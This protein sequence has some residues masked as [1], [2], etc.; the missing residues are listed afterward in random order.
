ILSMQ[1]S[2][3][4]K[5]S[6]Q[7]PNLSDTPTDKSSIDVLD[8]NENLVSVN[9]ER[10][11]GEKSPSSFSSS[12]PSIDS[13]EVDELCQVTGR[14]TLAGNQNIDRAENQSW[15]SLPWPA[16]RRAC[17]YLLIKKDCSNMANLSQVSTHFYTG[18]HQFMKIAENRPALS[19]AHLWRRK[20][21]LAVRVFLYPSNLP[22]Y[23]LASL[24]ARRFSR[25]RNHHGPHVEVDLKGPNDRII[26]QVVNLLSAP[27]G[28]V[29]IQGHVHGF[30]AEDL[31]LC[32]R[33]LRGS[34]IGKVEVQ[35]NLLDDVTSPSIL[36]IAS[37]AKVLEVT[38]QDTDLSDPASFVTQLASMDLTRVSL[39]DNF[40]SA[41][42]DLPNEFWTTFLNEKLSN[43]S[44]EYVEILGVG[45]ERTK[46]TKS[47]IDLPDHSFFS[48]IDWKKVTAN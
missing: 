16:L 11:A 26:E 13:G 40:F 15:E 4:S 3:S 29:T 8:A 35:R 9:E 14:L 19:S 46:F 31:S 6:A 5:S 39:C 22:F 38:T 42:L 47:P 36:E 12:I 21:R 24:N 25:Y 28:E 30:S 27:I 20:G 43:G 48:Y 44:F 45:M 34:T 18:V 33:V 17:D 32:A 41:L 2:K 23:G 10:P 37:S 1:T 7:K